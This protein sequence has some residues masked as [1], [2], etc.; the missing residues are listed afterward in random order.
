MCDRWGNNN[1]RRNLKARGERCALARIHAALPP[2]RMKPGRKNLV[3][4]AAAPHHLLNS[5]TGNDILHLGHI[6]FRPAAHISQCAI[7]GCRY[8]EPVFRQCDRRYRGKEALRPRLRAMPWQQSAGNG[9]GAG[10]GYGI[11]A[12]CETRRVVLVHQHGKNSL[13]YAFVVE[14]SET[15]TLAGGDLSAIAIQREGGE[16]ANGDGSVTDSKLSKP[17]VILGNPL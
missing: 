17:A 4:L 13:G 11:G 15:A 5:C 16:V 7:I 2:C 6:F 10:T 1:S 12:Q 3:I 14:P 8:E 9:T